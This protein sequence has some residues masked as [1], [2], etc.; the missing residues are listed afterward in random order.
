MAPASS[1]ALLSAFHFVALCFL[2]ILVLFVS[3]RVH[4]S[5][6]LQFAAIRFGNFLFC[7]YF[8]FGD[9]HFV[10]SHLRSPCQVSTRTKTRNGRHQCEKRDEQEEGEVSL[11]FIFVPILVTSSQ[12]HPVL[13]SFCFQLKLKQGGDVRM[14][15]Q[16][17]DSNR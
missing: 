14:L 3:S 16:G 9:F 8:C 2:G 12:T 17:G 4:L 1:C 10:L 6:S 11:W 7:H 5:V 15:W 13:F